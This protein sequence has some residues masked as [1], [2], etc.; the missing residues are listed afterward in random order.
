LLKMGGGGEGIW[1]RRVCETEI[2]TT[3]NRKF[4]NDFRGIDTPH[5]V[6]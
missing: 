4:G 3:N 5:V 2:Q 6:P 1:A